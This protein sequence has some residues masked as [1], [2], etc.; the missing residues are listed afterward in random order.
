MI[1]VAGEIK[2][3]RMVETGCSYGSS[4]LH[5]RATHRRSLALCQSFQE[6]LVDGQLLVYVE[7]CFIIDGNDME[8][9]TRQASLRVG[10]GPARG[11][12]GD[13]GR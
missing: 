5:Y 1:F 12:G 11:G 2:S 8:A 10:D 6:H 4:S 3:V 9:G 7:D 13:A